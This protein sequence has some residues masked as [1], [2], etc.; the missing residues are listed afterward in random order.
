MKIAIIGAGAAGLMAAGKAARDGVK[1][2]VYERNEKAGK[3]L[4][5]TGKGRCNVTN[6]STT[7]QFLSNVVSNPKFLYS[8]LNI[9]RAQDCVKFFEERGV[10]LV[11]ERGGRYFPATEHAS[12]ITK[13]LLKYAL[14]HPLSEIRYDAAVTAVEK[15]D[16]GFTVREESGAAQRFD[17]LIIAT[18]GVSYPATGSTG[19]GYR[20]AKSF[21]HTVIP[22]VPALCAILTEPTGLEG[23]SL[24]NIAV[25]AV[26][27]G[28]T[29]A[30]E[31]GEMLFTPEAV[32]GPAVLSLSS[33][34]NRKLK[35]GAELSIDLKPA[36]DPATLDA[37]ILSDFSEA[38]N[39]FFKNSLD[40]LL[41][42]SLIPKV[43]ERSGVDPDKPVNVVTKSERYALA[44]V[45]KGYTL[46][47]RGLDAI[48]NAVVTAGG[49]SVKEIH[50]GTMESRLVPGLY[51]AG[52][53]MDVDAFTGGFNIHIALATGYLAGF[54]AGKA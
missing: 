1:A 25:S 20:F 22:P 41:P 6:N 43:I 13:T 11:L 4:Y 18:G 38:G 34:I 50:P 26:Q 9:F 24:K 16:G 2:V 39:K 12:D 29:L 7:E 19:D 33:M 35:D 5:I 49:V 47:I 32:S 27:N 53:V 14:A 10:P 45:L 46:K 52:E 31:A 37:R 28:R 23:L 36:L 48:E 51:F 44:H 21:G 17:K 30:R 40:G 8:A 42:K 3:K 54:A 15:A